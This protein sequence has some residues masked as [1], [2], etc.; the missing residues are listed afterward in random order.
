MSRHIPHCIESSHSEKP[1]FDVFNL[2]TFVEQSNQLTPRETKLLN[3]IVELIKNRKYDDSDIC[4]PLEA[5]EDKDIYKWLKNYEII[6]LN[7]PFLDYL[8]QDTLRL[9]GYTE[10]NNQHPFNSEFTSIFG[11]IAKTFNVLKKSGS[12]SING[13]TLIKIMFSENKNVF[14][15]LPCSVVYIRPKDF[16]IIYKYLFNTSSKKSLKPTIE[17]IE[18]DPIFCNLLLKEDLTEIAKVSDGSV[19]YQIFDTLFNKQ[20]PFDLEEQKG[21]SK[22]RNYNEILGKAGLSKLLIKELFH[23]HNKK[24]ALKKSVNINKI[25]SL[26]S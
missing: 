4:F 23:I 17:A 21:I 6:D 10:N 5:E 16:E 20:E 1:I 3:E 14:Y 7:S 12:I 24:I 25:K 11:A 8:S 18:F 15:D 26:I 2:D 13:D 19:P 9:F 22:S